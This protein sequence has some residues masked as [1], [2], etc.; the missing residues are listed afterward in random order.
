[1][2]QFFFPQTYHLGLLFCNF[3]NPRN[4]MTKITLSDVPTARA[5]RLTGSENEDSD[6]ARS[7]GVNVINCTG[8]EN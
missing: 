3:L 4:E 2:K 5:S 1:M 6:E 8:E 7:T